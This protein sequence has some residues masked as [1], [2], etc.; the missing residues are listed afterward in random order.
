MSLSLPRRLC[1]P[2]FVRPATFSKAAASL[3][4]AALLGLA[5]VPTTHAQAP[6]QG[7]SGP[8][9][10]GGIAAQQGTP[11]SSPYFTSTQ[12]GYYG[13]NVNGKGLSCTGQ[14]EAQW[15]WSGNSTT[16]VPQQ[17][18][19]KQFSNASWESTTASGQCA[20]GLTNPTD[21][22]S[23]TSANGDTHSHCSGTHYS[24]VPA[25]ANGN[26]EVYC[27][28]S[29]KVSSGSCGVYY[30]ASATPLTINIGGA[31]PDS[32]GNLNI[33]VGQGCTASL[34]PMPNG[35]T[36]DSSSYH[37]SVSGTTFQSWTVS[38]DQSHTTEVDGLGT[39]TNSTAS[40]FWNDNLGSGKSQA[41]TVTCTATVT[42]PA[43][44]GTA[45]PITVTQKVTVY[46]PNWSCTGTGGTMQVNTESPNG[47]G[48]DY[49][50]YAGPA[51]GSDTG[52]GMYWN[53]T[54]SAPTAPVKF[55]AGVLELVQT[56]TPNSTYT[57][58]GGTVYNRS[59]NGQQG[60]DSQYPYGWLPQP[61]PPNYE[62]GDSPVAVDLTTSSV[63]SAQLKPSF[64]DTLMYEPP[65]SSQYVPLATFPWST[66]GSAQVPGT[67]NWADY[68]SGSAGVV[69][70]S[71]TQPFTASNAFPSWT[72]N[73]GNGSGWSW[74]AAK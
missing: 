37:W 28:P 58:L 41:E 66:N 64:V 21:P 3:T 50:L 23:T 53:A 5:A 69:A 39:T 4:F 22:V 32:S 44:Q 52:S 55:G 60:L 35:C 27:N 17:A 40:W 29:A 19:V 63:F 12:F 13:A 45:F 46:V 47:N 54:V 73:V 25:D 8:T 11:A 48:T 9:L 31:T 72:K 43:G 24:V 36:V 71:G 16:P 33:L 67:G 74:V 51:S 1:A 70:P 38:A 42:P 26:V 34:S 65:N 30:S 14:I 20:D 49:Y 62:N 15:I 68:G 7:Y 59:N 2:S 10:T 18:I 57:S 61:T 56:E 6:G